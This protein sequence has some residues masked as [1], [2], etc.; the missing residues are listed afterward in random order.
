MP[1][2]LIPTFLAHRSCS[3]LLS[4]IVMHRV[5]NGRAAKG[6]IH[7]DLEYVS[8]AR[9]LQLPSNRLT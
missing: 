5:G 2:T 7:H 9:L 3:Q 1:I 8:H 6:G 4:S